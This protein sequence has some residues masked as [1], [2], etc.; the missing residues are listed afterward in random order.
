MFEILPTP[1]GLHG[2]VVG[3]ERELL[4]DREAGERPRTFKIAP[5]SSPLAA[6]MQVNQ[7]FVSLSPWQSVIRLVNTHTHKC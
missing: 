1:A 7:L 3:A 4:Q 6:C 5:K 2:A